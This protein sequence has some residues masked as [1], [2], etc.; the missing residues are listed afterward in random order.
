MDQYLNYGPYICIGIVLVILF[1]M[2]IFWGGAN[3]EFVGLAPLAPETCA[4]YTGSIYSWNNVTPAEP[5]PMEAQEPVSIDPMSSETHPLEPQPV[6]SQLVESLPIEFRRSEPPIL[7]DRTPVLPENP[8]CLQEVTPTPNIRGT[9][10][11][12]IPPPGLARSKRLPSRGE[13]ICCQTLERIYGVP[14]KSIWPDWLVNPET[15]R[16]LE[17]DC[18]NEDLRIAVEYN[19][20]QHY[21]FPNFT[22]QSYE[23][24]INQVRRDRFKAELCERN[25]VYLIVVPYT[26]APEIIPDYIVRHLPETIQKRIRDEAVLSSLVA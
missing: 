23:D 26:V 24:F 21:K 4:A 17:L 25:G 15:G 12:V 5:Q 19:G 22:N 8:V 10:S 6:E 13:R 3:Y 7:I 9:N 20:E 14:F 18:Y 11:I 16:T 1:L 2:W